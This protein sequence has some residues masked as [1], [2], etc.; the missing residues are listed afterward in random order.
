MCVARAVVMDIVHGY[1]G[2]VAVHGRD[3]PQYPTQQHDMSIATHART[4]AIGA[5]VGSDSELTEPDGPARLGAACLTSP[6]GYSSDPQQGESP[7]ALPARRILYVGGA[8]GCPLCGAGCTCVNV[9]RMPIYTC[10]CMCVVV[11][12]VPAAAADDDADD[13]KPPVCCVLLLSC[14]SKALTLSTPGGCG[15]VGWMLAPPVYRRW[16]KWIAAVRPLWGVR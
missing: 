14:L 9:H 8:L 16:T 2:V 10:V 6:S 7:A 4:N 13:P 3:R 5:G 12:D 11:A 15:E 1:M